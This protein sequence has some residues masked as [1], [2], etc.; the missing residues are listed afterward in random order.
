MATKREA[1]NFTELHVRR[2]EQQN[3]VY[4]WYAVEGDLLIHVGDSLVSKSDVQKVQSNLYAN[5]GN[6]LAQGFTETFRKLG[7]PIT[8]AALLGVC[9]IESGA[10]AVIVGAIAKLFGS[11]GTAPAL[12]VSGF[13]LGVPVFFENVFYLLLPLAKA[14]GQKQP[15]MFLTAVMAIIVGATMA[16]SLVPPTRVRFWFAPRWGCP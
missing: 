8:M 2:S 15:R 10:A 4:V 12:T 16:H 1:G 11:R 7:I 9:L 6:E 3:G 14:V 5:V 13:L